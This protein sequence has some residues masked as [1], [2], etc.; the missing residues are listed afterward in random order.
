MF[1]NMK[2]STKRRNTVESQKRGLLEPPAWETTNE[3]L[4]WAATVLS[5]RRLR[6]AI[7]NR[8]LSPTTVS[9]E[10]VDESLGYSAENC[11]LIHSIF[12]SRGGVYQWTRERFQ[13]LSQM[14]EIQSSFNEEEVTEALAHDDAIRE[15]GGLRPVVYSKHVDECEWTEHEDIKDAAA[16]RNVTYRCVTNRAQNEYATPTDGIHFRYDRK[17]KRL[18]PNSL[19]TFF[20][21]IKNSTAQATKRRNKRGRDMSYDLTIR[22]LLELWRSQQ[23]RCAYTRVPMSTR[24]NTPCKCSPERIRNDIGYVTGNVVLVITECNSGTQWDL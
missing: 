1:S 11:I 3:F 9:I 14:A 8:R 18:S 5:E 17:R 23:G 10:R 13:S 2:T 20:Q 19:Y 16:Y 21:M 6:C 4:R 7:S 12:Q 15:Q 22:D 24:A